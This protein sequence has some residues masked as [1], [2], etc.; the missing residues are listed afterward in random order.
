VDFVGIKNITCC[1][2]ISC[3]AF[4]LSATSIK[5]SVDSASL[6]T[7]ISASRQALVEQRTEQGYWISG[8]ETNTLYTSLQIL[9]YFYLNR[10]DENR[11]NIAGLCR[12]LLSTQAQNGSWPFYDG[13][14]ADRSLTVLN[15]FALKLSGYGL[16]EPAMQRSYDYIRSHGGAEATSSMYKILLALF[17]QFSFPEIPAFPAQSLIYIAPQLSWLRIMEIPLMVVIQEKAFYHPSAQSTI[18]ELFLNKTSGMSISLEPEI[19]SLLQ[20]AAAEV[21]ISPQEMTRVTS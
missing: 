1:I 8:V 19:V 5:A 12:Y 2:V 6:E 14:A 7:A 4:L 20:S 11:D 13:G 9:L 18:D 16:E 15:Y 3:S 21:E 10:Q 17:N